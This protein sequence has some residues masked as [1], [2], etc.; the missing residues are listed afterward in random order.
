MAPVAVTDISPGALMIGLSGDELMGIGIHPQA[1]GSLYDRITLQALADV[2]A[3]HQSQLVIFQELTGRNIEDHEVAAFVEES[4]RLLEI[5]TGALAQ[6]LTL[7]FRENQENM[8]SPPAA[9]GFYG[10]PSSQVHT[11]ER[12]ALIVART[13]APEWYFW[14]R[15]DDLE[16]RG[17]LGPEWIIFPLEDPW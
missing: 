4:N 13:L 3:T 9:R 5:L 6:R 7:L 8:L 16:A 2:A 12:I 15:N 1:L 14:D 17:A 10:H 11:I